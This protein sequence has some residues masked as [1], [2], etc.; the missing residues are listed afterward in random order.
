MADSRCR[1][2]AR[3][4]VIGVL[5]DH[6]DAALA[7]RAGPV[8]ERLLVDWHCGHGRRVEE[9]C[10]V[11]VEDGGATSK[12][13]GTSTKPQLRLCANHRAIAP[14]Q[15]GAPDC[16]A[17][18]VVPR[19]R[20]GKCLE[21]RLHQLE[22]GV[23]P[24]D[25]R[26]GSIGFARVVLHDRIGPFAQHVDRGIP[27]VPLRGGQRRRQRQRDDERADHRGSR[28]TRMWAMAAIRYGASASPETKWNTQAGPLLVR[29]SMKLL[30]AAGSVDVGRVVVL[31]AA[32]LTWVAW[33]IVRDLRR[34]HRTGISREA[35]GTRLQCV[36]GLQRAPERVSGP[37]RGGHP[38]TGHAAAGVNQ[39]ADGL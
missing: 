10:G 34:M 27:G 18:I 13:V 9:Q 31:L 22:I 17:R 20:A 5:A 25:S 12:L 1:L 30:V 28:S 33:T 36:A 21:E 3:S 29:P 35:T 6:V 23:A 4:V 2:C 37:N 19:G 24:V 8:W 26:Q 38:F 14:A 16:R 15:P 11:R 7:P 39:N 32:G